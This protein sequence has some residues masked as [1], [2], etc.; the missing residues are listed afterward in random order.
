MSDP[1]DIRA[2]EAELRNLRQ[3]LTITQR[4]VDTLGGNQLRYPLDKE[5]ASVLKKN[6]HDQLTDELWDLDAR[7][8]M[9][10]SSAFEYVNL[11]GVEDGSPDSYGWFVLNPAD[12]VASYRGVQILT[13]ATTGDFNELYK[14]IS[15]TGVEIYYFNRARLRFIFNWNTAPLSPATMYLTLGRIDE[16]Q[17][18]GFKVV[19][20]G[21]GAE[22]YGVAYSENSAGSLVTRGI[23][24]SATGG[25]DI[26][27][28]TTSPHGFTTGDTVTVSGHSQSS[29]NGT[30]VITVINSTQ[31]DLDT[32][33]F[34]ANGTGGL[35]SKNLGTATEQSV[36]L[37]TDV[38]GEIN[39]AR[40]EA[41]LVPGL[42]INFYLTTGF[43]PNTYEATSGGKPFPLG[44]GILKNPIP[45]NTQKGSATDTLFYLYAKTDADDVTGLQVSFCEYTTELQLPL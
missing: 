23:A 19:T 11:T 35:V 45:P 4:K 14:G 10:Y 22:V 24:S 32:S 34:V 8:Y 27:I 43:D 13:G 42:G 15:S 7:R 26:R 31:F 38:S 25:G 41:V 2:L 21:A 20:T 3:D 40:G 16:G 30:W 36:L 18:W 6:L 12:F 1:R 33:V 39:F 29:A 17:Y 9:R 37:Y 5:T 28:T 44:S